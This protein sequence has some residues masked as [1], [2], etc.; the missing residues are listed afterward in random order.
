MTKKSFL[1]H[2][3]PNLGQKLG[4]WCL[5]PS[6]FPGRWLV[7]IWSCLLFCEPQEH[8]RGC[9]FHFFEKLCLRPV[10]ALWK[11]S[12]TS[13]LGFWCLTPSQ[14][15][16]WWL[17]QIWLCLLFC[18]PQVHIWGCI[19]YFFEKSCLRPIRAL[20][21]WSRMPKLGFWCLTPPRFPGRWLVQIWLCL[22]FCEPQVHIRGCIFHFFEKLCLRPTRALRKWS[23]MP[24][25][26]FW[27]HSPS[28]FSGWWLVQIW[29]CLLFCEPLVHIWG[30]IFHFLENLCLRPIRAL[31]KWSRRPK[32][33]FWCLLPSQFPGWW[34][35]QI[36]LCLLFC[37]PQVHIRG[38]IFHFFEK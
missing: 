8:I 37:K 9:I 29:L 20:R 17:V 15:L 30:C 32:L 31:W 33:G 28:Q 27:C 4:F 10:R 5:T 22:L 6:Q 36:W 12:R 23:R 14:F 2:F 13:K 21:K 7:Q 18:E 25:L 16:G 35:V 26:G 3:W 24:K 19:F 34:L 38:C 1:G 11:W